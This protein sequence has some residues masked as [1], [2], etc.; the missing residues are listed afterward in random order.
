MGYLIK[1]ASL[2][3]VGAPFI[4]FPAEKKV[5]MELK[6]DTLQKYQP[7]AQPL[8]I[9]QADHHLLHR[10]QARIFNEITHAPYQI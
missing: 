3:W 1:D 4:P 9:P 8:P 2:A 5:V 10:R 6:K 7:V